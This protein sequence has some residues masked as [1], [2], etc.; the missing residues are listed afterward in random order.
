LTEYIY[1]LAT[2]ENHCCQPRFTALVKDS[3]GSLLKSTHNT[4]CQALKLHLVTHFEWNQHDTKNFLFLQGL[5]ITWNEDGSLVVGGPTCKAI[6]ACKGSNV[7]T[8]NQKWWLANHLGF[9]ASLF[10]N[11][12]VTQSFATVISTQ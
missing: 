4:I 5:L 9:W 11:R 7:H 10:S 1:F 12:G 2:R 3:G 6:Q 8:Q